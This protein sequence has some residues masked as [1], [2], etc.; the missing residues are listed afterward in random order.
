MGMKSRGEAVSTL[1]WRV[2]HGR[3]TTEQVDADVLFGRLAERVNQALNS[4]PVR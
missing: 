1:I 3:G 4:L 2:K